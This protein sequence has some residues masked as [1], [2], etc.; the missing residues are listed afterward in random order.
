MGMAPWG[1]MSDGG[2]EVA[3]EREERGETIAPVPATASATASASTVVNCGY[4]KMETV[5][6]CLLQPQ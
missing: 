5:C 2:T 1:Y 6:I 3:A 4:R